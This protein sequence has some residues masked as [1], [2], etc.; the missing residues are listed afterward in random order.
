MG[1]NVGDM[2][3]RASGPAAKL[4]DRLQMRKK[5]ML[6]AS[7]FIA[8]LLLLFALLLPRLNADLEFVRNELRGAAL[9]AP[10]GAAASAIARLGMARQSA[11]SGNATTLAPV[12]QLRGEV[13]RHIEAIGATLAVNASGW[14]TDDEWL[15]V[16]AAWQAL[17]ASSSTDPAAVFEEHLAMLRTLDALLARITIDSSLA[18]DPALGTYGLMDAATTRLPLMSIATVASHGHASKAVAR[19][20]TVVQDL[21]DTTGELRIMDLALGQAESILAAAYEADPALKDLLGA[22]VARLREAHAAFGEALRSGLMLGAPPTVDQP[23]LERRSGAMV[24]TIEE[25]QKQASDTLAVKL[26]EREKALVNARAVSMAG[27]ALLVLVAFYLFLGFN[28]SLRATLRG[29]ARASASLAAGDFPQRID[30]RS[31]DE[32]Q[33]IADELT[34]I[35]LSLRRFDAAQREMTAS[36]EAGETDARVDATALPGAFAQLARAVNE[37]A[38]GHL[39]VQRRMAEVA[40]SYSRGDLSVAMDRLPGKRAAMTAAM[41]GI[42][43]NLGAVNGA[44]LDLSNA[45]AAGD[46]ARRGDAARFEFAFREMVE[47]LNTLMAR[48]ESGLNDVGGM[49]GALAAGDLTARMNG[50]YHGLFRR[51]RDDA[52]ATAERLS[53]IVGGIKVAAESI[54]VAAREI[55]SGNQDLSQRTEEQAAS[56]EETAASMEELTATVRANAENAKQANQLAAGAGDAARRGGAVVAE[57]VGNMSAIAD[58]SRR[59]DEIIAVIDGIAFQTNI[60]ALNAAVEAARAGEQGRG[61]AVVASEVRALAQRSAA[62]AKEIK[63]LIVDSSARVHSGNQMVARAGEAMAEI[64]EAVRRVNDIM[65]EI[66]AAS[67]EQSSGI[68]QVSDTVGQ[69]DQATQQNAALVEEATAAARALEEQAAG[70]VRAVSVFRVDELRAPVPA[71]RPMRVA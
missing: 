64:V 30:L 20:E 38:D 47:S 11:I 4:M 10:S 32:M 21:V 34:K 71:T 63:G 26:A 12:E 70:M 15:A 37:L 40:T 49:L 2:L 16:S 42:R 1:F 35:G 31:R 67:T 39:A 66:S 50:D 41:D 27:V 55:A 58:S 45:A 22:E 61:F 19:G 68:Q 25:I 69:M 23:T 48:S 6:M 13:G 65:G 29:L 9:I 60:L 24:V 56:L 43:D 8:A 17:D 18:L 33:D 57:V 36:H 28:R 54:D 7:V 62:A 59:M 44:I 52:H 3:Y 51:M 46:F 53:S 5:L 14:Q